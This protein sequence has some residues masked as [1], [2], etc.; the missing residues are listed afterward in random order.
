MPEFV[1][2][3]VSV[4]VPIY[5]VE[6]FLRDCLDSIRSQTYRELQVVLVDDGCTDGSVA[7]AEEFVAADSRFT[8]IRQRNA[9]LS[10]AR[11]AGM[12]MVEHDDVV[13]FLDDDMVPGEHL[14][15]RHVDGHRAGDEPHVL[16]GPCLFP[17]DRRV[18]G[19]NREWADH[20]FRELSASGEVRSAGL[21]RRFPQPSASRTKA[22]SPPTREA[23]F[24]SQISTSTAIAVASSA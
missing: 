2:G 8:L 13:W 11:N 23:S 18:V 6:A 9:G 4:V 20:V 3:L 5:N 1:P 17:E 14:V 7:I 19:M 22:A 12:A 24:P 16:M 10:A 15:R 21:A